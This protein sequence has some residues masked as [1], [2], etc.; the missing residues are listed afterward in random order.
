[1]FV[2]PSEG[3]CAFSSQPLLNDLTGIRKVTVIVVAYLV[4]VV[5][6]AGPRWTSAQRHWVAAAAKRESWVSVQ[7]LKTLLFIVAGVWIARDGSFQEVTLPL[8][9]VDLAVRQVFI[10]LLNAHIVG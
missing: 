9:P 10:V 5:V 8:I 4:D 2:V 7:L 1:V 6:S 3:F